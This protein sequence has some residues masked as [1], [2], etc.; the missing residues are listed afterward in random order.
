VVGPGYRWLYWMGL[1]F[2]ALYVPLN[3]WRKMED[4]VAGRGEAALDTSSGGSN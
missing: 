3:W 2:V 1:I 4:R